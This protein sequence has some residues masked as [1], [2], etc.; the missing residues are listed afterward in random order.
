MDDDLFSLVPFKLM[1]IIINDDF[2]KITKGLAPNNVK[3]CLN[4]SMLIY[5]MTS[6]R[7]VWIIDL[8][9]KHFRPIMCTPNDQC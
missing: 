9:H 5:K 2:E 6:L 3:K 7:F 8:L 4:I 1:L